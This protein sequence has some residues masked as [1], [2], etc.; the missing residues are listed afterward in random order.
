[1][2]DRD[3]SGTINIYEFSDLFKYINQWKAMFEGI[4]RDRS[5]FIEQA[6]LQQGT[7]KL[8]PYQFLQISLTKT[9]AARSTLTSSPSCSRSLSSGRPSSRATIKTGP[10]GSSKTSW[11]KVRRGML[12]SSVLLSE[13][14]CSWF[15]MNTACVVH[16]TTLLTRKDEGVSEVPRLPSLFVKATCT[17][18]VFSLP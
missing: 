3:K 11:T 17:N 6:E 8:I 12:P 13:F 2:F 7:A 16:C 10:A 4:D 14:G 18:F 1:M 15:E 5:G 9:R